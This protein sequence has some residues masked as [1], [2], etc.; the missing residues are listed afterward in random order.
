MN[1]AELMPI[2]DKSFSFFFVLRILSASFHQ[3]ILIITFF[4]PALEFTHCK[5]QYYQDELQYQ[6]LKA[7]SEFPL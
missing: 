2:E 5:P 3:D 6:F 1:T 7:S 4:G